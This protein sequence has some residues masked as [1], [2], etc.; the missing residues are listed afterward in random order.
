MF[1]DLYFDLFFLGLFGVV[2]GDGQIR[3]LFLFVV[4]GDVFIEYNFVR[5]IKYVKGYGKGN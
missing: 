5:E 3:I 2:D 1:L 4:Q